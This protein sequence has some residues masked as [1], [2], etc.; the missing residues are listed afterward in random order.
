MSYPQAYRN[1][2]LTQLLKTSPLNH[3][4]TPANKVVI[5]LET[6]FD[7]SSPTNLLTPACLKTEWMDDDIQ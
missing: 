5:M 2:C 4:D 1:K 6:I 3:T 7:A